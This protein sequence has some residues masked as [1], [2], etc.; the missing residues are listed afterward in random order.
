MTV[1]VHPSL[2][3]DITYRAGLLLTLRHSVRL[4]EMLHTTE[5]QIPKAQAHE[6]LVP[7][8]GHCPGSV[9]LHHPPEER[10]LQRPLT[11]PWLIDGTPGN[12]IEKDIENRHSFLP[13]FQRE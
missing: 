1:T 3:T 9:G 6:G 12:L 11:H 5:N 7:G 4:R 13:L 2:L 10:L 8:H